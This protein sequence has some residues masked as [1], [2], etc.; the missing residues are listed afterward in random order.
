LKLLATLLAF[1]AWPALAQ[2]AATPTVYA[3]TFSWQAP[4][5]CSDGTPIAPTATT[6]GCALTK[7]TLYTAPQGQPLTVWGTLSPTTL[8]VQATNTPPGT[9]CGAIT[10]SD[11]AGESAQSPMVCI[12]LGP[13]PGSPANGSVTLVTSSTIAYML[14]AGSNTFGALIVGSVPLGTTCD[15][16]QIHAVNG[17]PYY[18]IPSASVTPT[19]P[20]T[21]LTTVLGSCH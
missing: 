5:T 15:A 9:W 16:T 2:T 17:V 21:K 12:T 18:V 20:I 4:T 6:P 7:Y 14:V 8:S 11:A 3:P 1:F 19:G 13:V 10:A